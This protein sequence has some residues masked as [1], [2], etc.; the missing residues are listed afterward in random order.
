MHHLHP[1]ITFNLLVLAYRGSKQKEILAKSFHNIPQ[2]GKGKNKFSD[3][4]LQHFVQMLISE[5]VIVEKLRGTNENGSMPY[6]VPGSQA[7]ALANGELSI[8]RYKM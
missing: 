8:Y 6:L 2:Y 3:S 1:K 7:E 4:S 5:N